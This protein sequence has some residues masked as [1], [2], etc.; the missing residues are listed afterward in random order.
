M[1]YEFFQRFLQINQPS[2]IAMSGDF[3]PFF[4]FKVYFILKADVLLKI[5]RNLIQIHRNLSDLSTSQSMQVLAF[6]F[7]KYKL[8]VVSI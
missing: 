3:R 7:C 6:V 1:N 5:N 4:S 8:K 2:K